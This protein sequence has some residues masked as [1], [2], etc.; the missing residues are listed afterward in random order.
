MNKQDEITKTQNEIMQEQ[1]LNFM[2][3]LESFKGALQYGVQ[4][5]KSLFMVTGG[6]AAA[7]LAFM[8]HMAANDK[9]AH[10]RLLVVPL[11]VFFTASVFACG[12]FAFSYLSQCD[13]TANKTAW[14]VRLKACAIITTILSFALCFAAMYC[15]YRSFMRF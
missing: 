8:G 11:G 13:A 2:G 15:S 10:V 6:S 5:M 12:S 1:E 14:A 3:R 9:M 7:L 4:T